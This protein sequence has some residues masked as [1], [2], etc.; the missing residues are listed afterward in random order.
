LNPPEP[1]VFEEPWQAEAFALVV[2]LHD[3][4]AFTW[5]EWAEAL[6][7]QIRSAGGGGSMHEDGARYYDHWL[8]ALE[9]LATGRGMTDPDALASRK[10][11]W[12]EAYRHTPHG[13]PVTL[14]A[15]GA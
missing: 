2:H 1:P 15:A 8:A 13:R 5:S 3:R 14:A 10:A 9:S 12:A 7:A 11:A 6:T 4:G